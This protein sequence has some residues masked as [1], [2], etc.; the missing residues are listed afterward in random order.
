MLHV[1]AKSSTRS[2]FPDAA[3]HFEKPMAACGKLLD[4]PCGVSNDFA[5]P[6]ALADSH[7]RAMDIFATLVQLDDPDSV[8]SEMWGMG[9]RVPD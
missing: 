7:R 6:E 3:S 9:S 5:R 4:H 2:D 1:G 8:R